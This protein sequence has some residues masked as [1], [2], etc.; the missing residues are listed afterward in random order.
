MQ[1]CGNS[2]LDGAILFPFFWSSFSLATWK[3]AE[4]KGWRKF[5]P[6]WGH[7][8]L[9]LQYLKT[10]FTFICKFA[11]LISCFYPN[12]NEKY[13]FYFRP[14]VL[15]LIADERTAAQLIFHT[16]T[17]N[18]KNSAE[19]QLIVLPWCSPANHFGFSWL[20]NPNMLVENIRRLGF[21]WAIWKS[22]W[23]HFFFLT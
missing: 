22:R 14:F 4:R 18:F 5:K 23:E 17:T 10:F 13:A 16:K 21:K 12:C 19:N 1:P 11:S 9:K 2:N 3:G 7:L 8:F 6:R 15:C 20:E